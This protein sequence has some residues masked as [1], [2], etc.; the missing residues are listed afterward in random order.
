MQSENLIKCAHAACQCLVETE[1]QFCSAVCASAKD[2]HVTPCPCGH[3]ECVGTEQAVEQE[4]EFEAPAE[5][6]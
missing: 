5:V 6:Y 3:P 2:T 1:D 4:D